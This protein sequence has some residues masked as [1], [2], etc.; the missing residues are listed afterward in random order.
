MRPM[1]FHSPAEGEQA[2]VCGR[3]LRIYQ[4]CAE[5]GSIMS[6]NSIQTGIIVGELNKLNKM[7]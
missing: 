7:Y 3:E 4:G 2:G 5:S 1:R 6:E